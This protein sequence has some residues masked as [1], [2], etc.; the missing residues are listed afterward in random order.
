MVA[1][2]LVEIAAF[3]KCALEAS[4]DFRRNGLVV[5][6]LAAYDKPH[7][8]NSGFGVVLAPLY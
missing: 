4:I 1:D 3:C 6:P 7:R 2:M 8:E 5:V